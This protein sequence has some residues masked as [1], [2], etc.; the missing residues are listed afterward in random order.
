MEH[1][2]DSEYFTT[3]QDAVN[4]ITELIP[5]G[6]KPGLKRMEYMMEL[7]GHPHRRLKF[8]HVAGT[9]GKGST[10]AYLTQV[11]IESG[12][13]VGSFNSPYITKYTDRIQCNGEDIP[14]QTV[15]EIVNLLKPISDELALSELGAPTSFEITTAL[16]LVYFARYAYPDFVVMETGLGGRLDC[17]NIIFPIV[18]VITNIGHDHMDILGNSLEEIALEKAGIIKAGVPIVS[19][20]E[21]PELIELLEGIATSKRSTIYQSGKAF[22]YQL[23]DIR[24]DQLTFSFTGPFRTINPLTI[25]LNGEHQVKNAA[26]AMMTLEVLR[27]YYAVIID[28]ENL[29]TGLIGTKWPGRLEMVQQNPRLV[30]DGAHN[31]EGAETLTKALSSIY[32][33]KKLHFMMGM[34]STKNHSDYLW[35]ILP[36]V[37]TLIVTEPVFRKKMDAHLLAE[38]VEQ[39]RTSRAKPD[40][41]VIVEP[42]W[43]EALSKLNEITS[44]D[45]LAVVSG[46]LYLI[47]DVRSWI[48]NH[49][50]S[51]KG[52]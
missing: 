31:P 48:L 37:D 35:H 3:Y 50:T 2:T 25:S 21:Q 6:I 39:L 49:K 52:W 26:L 12:Y 8:I 32:P 27:Q 18:S 29:L 28:D 42:D 41:K 9:N 15:K 23:D 36:I 40:L 44:N 43:Q 33:Y 13:V 16:A 14:E 46:T 47:S 20:V 38:L 1:T 10:C 7:L 30:I 5:F 45:D 24:L 34:L 19:S 4:W 11:L 17:T 22:T 51:E